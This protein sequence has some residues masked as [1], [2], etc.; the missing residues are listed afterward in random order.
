[1]FELADS[2]LFNAVLHSTTAPPPA[3]NRTNLLSELM[4]QNCQISERMKVYGVK[5]KGMR[6]QGRHI[7]TEYRAGCLF[8]KF[9]VPTPP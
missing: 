7:A 9:R 6:W 1:M 4:I 3:Q 5:S 2:F 8:L